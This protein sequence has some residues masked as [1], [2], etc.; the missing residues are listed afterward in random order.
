M[1]RLLHTADWHIEKSLA[2]KT[3]QYVKVITGLPSAPKTDR[4]VVVVAK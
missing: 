1:F 2:G 4:S 3:F